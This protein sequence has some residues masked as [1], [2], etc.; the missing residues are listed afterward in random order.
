MLLTLALG[1]ACSGHSERGLGVVRTLKS[2]II[3]GESLPTVGRL[4]VQTPRPAAKQGIT[5][6]RQATSGKKVLLFAEFRCIFTMSVLAYIVVVV[7]T[8]LGEIS[9]NIK[10][11]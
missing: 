8:N 6:R 4:T 11:W 2:R 10:S 7:S 5:D 3:G 1:W 9:D